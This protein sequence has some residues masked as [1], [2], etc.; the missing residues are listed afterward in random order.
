MVKAPLTKSKFIYQVKK[1]HYLQQREVAI[2]T[3]RNRDLTEWIRH[4]HWHK[5]LVQQQSWAK[6]YKIRVRSFLHNEDNRW[7]EIDVDVMKHLKTLRCRL[8]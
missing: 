7:P 8:P 6:L 1:V 2:E 3:Q 5:C 4:F